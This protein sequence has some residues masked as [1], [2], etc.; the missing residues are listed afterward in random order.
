M[1][2]FALK[3]SLELIACEKAPAS[4]EP[5]VVDHRGRA[6]CGQG[7]MTV[8]ECCSRGQDWSHLSRVRFKD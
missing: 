2:H 8:M 1:W 4:W 7:D 5:G 6:G 3:L